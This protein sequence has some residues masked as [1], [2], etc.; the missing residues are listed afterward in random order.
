MCIC[1]RTGAGDDDGSAA[2]G[3]QGVGPP[4]DELEGKGDHGQ[5][6][7]EESE[8]AKHGYLWAVRG[9]GWGKGRCET[10][11]AWWMVCRM[12]CV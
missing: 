10:R 3:R 2:G 5:K 11:W 9:A 7:A 4:R 8:L 6:D 12:V 1:I